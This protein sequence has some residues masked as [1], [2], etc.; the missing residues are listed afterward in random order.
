MSDMS[1]IATRIATSSVFQLQAQKLVQQAPK[2]QNGDHAKIEKAATDFESILLGQ[3]LEEAEQSFGSA[4][5]ADPDADQDLDPG[6]S[7]FQGLA[8]QSLAKSLTKSGGIGIAKMIV[9]QLEATQNKAGSPT[10]IEP[11]NR[12]TPDGMSAQKVPRK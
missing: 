5:G 6:H 8:I 11:V 2:I 4:P 3:W 7:Q 12:V 10:A 1:D 9:R